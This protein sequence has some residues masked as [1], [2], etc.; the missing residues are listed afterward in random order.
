M[1]TCFAGPEV[2]RQALSSKRC[3]RQVGNAGGGQRNASSVILTQ[4]RAEFPHVG[5]Y[6]SNAILTG[7]FYVALVLEL[8]KQ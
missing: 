4:P 3:R 6:Q 1:R 8:L 7:L 5:A 2:L